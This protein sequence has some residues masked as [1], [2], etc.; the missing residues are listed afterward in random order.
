MVDMDKN[1]SYI[2][3]TIDI[4][5]SYEFIWLDDKRILSG[6]IDQQQQSNDIKITM[7][8]EHIFHMQM[9][10][11][12]GISVHFILPLNMHTQLYMIW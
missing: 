4:W 3:P 12:I 2:L 8:L 6:H 9:K 10:R 11:R 1:M 7:R 5:E